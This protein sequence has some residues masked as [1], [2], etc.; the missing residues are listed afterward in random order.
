MAARGESRQDVELSRPQAD[1]REV[2]AVRSTNFP[3]GRGDWG[4]AAAPLSRSHAVKKLYSVDLKVNGTV[5]Q[6]LYK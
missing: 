6:D 4:A 2:S 5:P 3:R 1:G